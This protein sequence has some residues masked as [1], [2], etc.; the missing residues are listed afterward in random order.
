MIPHTAAVS[1]GGLIHNLIWVTAG[2]FVGGAVF[3]GAA[4]WYI[5]KDKQ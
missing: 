4:Y 3:I 2:N 1:I 5:S